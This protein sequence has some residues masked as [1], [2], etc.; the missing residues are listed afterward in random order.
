MILTHTE[1]ISALAVAASLVVPALTEAV[2]KRF[3]RPE[4]A[5]AA[6]HDQHG[7]LVAELAGCRS[8]IAGCRAE[9]AALK[10]EAAATEAGKDVAEQSEE[11]FRRR[12][13]S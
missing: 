12:C 5:R 10:A 9:I 7:E 4:S 3:G 6:A 8:E 2:K 11:A 13:H 1:Y